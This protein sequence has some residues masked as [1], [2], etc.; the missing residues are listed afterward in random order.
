MGPETRKSVAEEI[1]T[2]LR[3]AIVNGRLEPGSALPSERDL[4]QQHGVNRSSIREAVKRLE[5]WGLVK[6]RPGAATRVTDALL[7]AGGELG[8][9][10]MR[11]LH[12]LR[13]LLLG[14]SAE[15][16]ATK[17]DAASLE[18]LDELVKAMCV[19]RV[20]ASD[21]QVLDYDFFEQLVT[22]TGNQLLAVF[23]KVVRDIYF[24]GAARFLPLYRTGVFDPRHHRRAVAAMR[25]RDP[26]AAG[27]AMRAHAA[28]GLQLVKEAP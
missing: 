6:V 12:E 26:V 10:I 7:E 19:P 9:S 5:A 4:A 17:A 24:R 3:E 15:Q 13:G 8:S 27:E 1:A 23:A 21:L 22:I 18:R 14:W 25:A 16:A 11:D 28:S 2:A 20:K